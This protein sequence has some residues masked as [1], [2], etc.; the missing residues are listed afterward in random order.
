MLNR[1]FCKVVSCLLI[2]SV[3]LGLGVTPSKVSAAGTTAVTGL[4][5]SVGSK[6]VTKTTYSMAVGKKKTLTVS[7]K[8]KAAAQV[9]TF[10]SSDTSIVTVSS[11]GNV[12]ALRPGTAKITVTISSSKYKKTT[13]WVKIKVKDYSLKV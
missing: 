11:A 9:A 10:K 8:P 6:D 4:K 1:R 12:S 3:V 5:I 7:A 13:T 2:L